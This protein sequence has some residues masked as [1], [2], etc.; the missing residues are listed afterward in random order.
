M[1]IIGHRYL[2]WAHTP[3]VNICCKL[4]S[5]ILLNE[6]RHF[7]G[8][9]INIALVPY[10]PRV[11]YTDVRNW[12]KIQECCSISDTSSVNMGITQWVHWFIHLTALPCR[13]WPNPQGATGSLYKCTACDEVVEFLDHLIYMIVCTAPNCLVDFHPCPAPH[14]PAHPWILHQHG[15]LLIGGKQINQILS[16]NL[17]LPTPTSYFD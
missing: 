15:L 17:G 12:F 5:D 3:G 6:K 11:R 2:F 7:Q 4:H 13:N 10:L 8:K 16:Q 14:C 1:R 9:S